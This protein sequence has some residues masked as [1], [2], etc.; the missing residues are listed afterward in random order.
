MF[1]KIKI[2]GHP[3]HAM[4]VPFPVAFYTATMV[5]FISY[6]NCLDPFWFKVAV[7]A[8]CAGVITAVIAALPGFIDWLF[9]PKERRAKKVGLMH[10][11]CNVVALLL[12]AINLYLQA[13]KLNE[14]LPEESPAILLTVLGFVLTLVAG[15]LGWSLVQKHHVG[16]LLTPEQQQIDPPDGVK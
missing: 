13:P 2:A 12:F 3:L 4:L 14:P 10:M 16:V 8:N 5:C 1:S 9:I 7:K 15:F 11:L 6:S